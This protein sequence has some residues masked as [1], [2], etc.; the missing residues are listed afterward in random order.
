MRLSMTLVP[1][2][3]L[4]HRRRLKGAR[5]MQESDSIGERF[6][7]RSL[8]CHVTQ[9]ARPTPAPYADDN[10]GAGAG[11]VSSGFTLGIIL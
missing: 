5:M 10:S 2:G 1:N 9:T 11:R 8:L 4:V 3:P 6:H 7:L